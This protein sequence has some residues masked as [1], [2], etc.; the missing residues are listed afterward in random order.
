MIGNN[1]ILIDNIL[2]WLQ[3]FDISK[4]DTD[5]NKNNEFQ[6]SFFH[7]FSKQISLLVYK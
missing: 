6:S 2:P 5:V 4:M 7:T 3:N 1:E